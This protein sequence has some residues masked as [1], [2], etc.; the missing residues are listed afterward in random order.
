LADSYNGIFQNHKRQNNRI[1]LAKSADA[2]NLEKMSS[3]MFNL[4]EPGEREANI[5]RV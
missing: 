1:E 5:G 3:E 2:G 4:E